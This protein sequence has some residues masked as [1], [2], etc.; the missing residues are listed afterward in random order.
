VVL[1]AGYVGADSPKYLAVGSREE[2][3]RLA[4]EDSRHL[5]ALVLVSG[6]PDLWNDPEQLEAAARALVEGQNLRP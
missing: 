6:E 5:V 3:L 2:G 4:L 1:G